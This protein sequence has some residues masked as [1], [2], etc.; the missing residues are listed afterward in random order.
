MDQ[1]AVIDVGSGFT[2]IGINSEQLP[3]KTFESAVNGH[4]YGREA[5]KKGGV[6]KYVM[7]KGYW[8]NFD[9]MNKYLDH[10]YKDEFVVRPDDYGVIMTES[11]SSQ[12]N[13][14]E[15]LVKLMFEQY[16][17][18]YFY[19]ARQDVL[20]ALS[21]G[22]LTAAV[23]ESGYGVTLA[24]VIYEGYAINNLTHKLE[25][26][27]ADVDDALMKILIEERGVVFATDSERYQVRLIKEK[28]C[29][30]ASQQSAFDS[31]DVTTD[32]FELP[33]GRVITIGDVE[34]YKPSELLF[35]PREFGFNSDGVHESLAQCIN[36]SDE[37]L[38]PWLYKNI[39]CGGGNTAFSGI[40]TRLQ[41]E[42]SELSSTITVHVEA[43][44]SRK[45][46]AWI[47]AAMLSSLSTFEKMAMRRSQ[48]DEVGEQLVHRVCFN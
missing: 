9:T 5:L 34:K 29:N 7:E 28:F 37:E 27:A 15:K 4:A 18:P 2:K 48:Y 21:A 6:H 41:N 8:I 31:T 44:V 10:I 1:V 11:P 39:I 23:L 13:Y 12:K 33:D 32:T 47:G 14:R 45:Y 46:S 19:L 17:V 38:R 40:D 25:I 43:P 26:G 3:L 20:T 30:V 22:K 24:S 36:R 42:I 16:D 35:Y